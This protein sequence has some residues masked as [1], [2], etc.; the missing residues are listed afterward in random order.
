M[1]VLNRPSHVLN[2][3]IKIIRYRMVMI[4]L[5]RVVLGSVGRD[6]PEPGGA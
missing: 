1:M 2:M 5:L 4:A 6:S 3:D